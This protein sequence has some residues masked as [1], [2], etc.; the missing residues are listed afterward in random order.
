MKGKQIYFTKQELIALL[1]TFEYFQ[2]YSSETV[3]AQMLYRGLGTAW[4]KIKDCVEPSEL[5]E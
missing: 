4:H 3:Y 5:P 1:L 2:E